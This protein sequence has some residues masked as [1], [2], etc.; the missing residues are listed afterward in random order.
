MYSHFSER[1]SESETRMFPQHTH[2]RNPR[3]QSR[4]RE[5]LADA[6]T[7]ASRFSDGVRILLRRRNHTCLGRALLVVGILCLRLGRRSKTMRCASN[8]SMQPLR[9]TS[10]KMA[11]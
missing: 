9:S 11:F 10:F 4:A 1:T 2:V 5:R 7:D 3:L 6:A 8:A